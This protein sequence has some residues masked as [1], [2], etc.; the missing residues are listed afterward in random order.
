MRAMVPKHIVPIGHDAPDGARAHR[1]ER[2]RIAPAAQSARHQGG[3]TLAGFIDRF[4][5]GEGLVL[6]LDTVKRTVAVLAPRGGTRT[7]AATVLVEEMVADR[8]PVVILDPSGT[9]HGLSRATDG[10]GPG[11]PVRILGGA[12]GGLEVREHSGAM[13]AD[14]A[15]DWQQPLVVDLSSLTPRGAHRFV[16]DFA[17]QVGLRSPRI[18]H[19]VV[20][21][22]HELFAGLGGRAGPLFELLSFAGRSGAIG[23][24]L[25]SDRPSEISP[26]VLEHVD[27]LVAARTR[28]PSEH[29][30]IRSWLKPRVDEGTARR[31]LEALP[32]LE[33][34]EAWVCSPAWLR[35][36]RRVTLRH[37]ATYNGFGARLNPLRPPQSRAAAAE[38]RR[39]H[40]RLGEAREWPPPFTAFRAPT[41]PNLPYALSEGGPELDDL[42]VA[43]AADDEQVGKRRRGRPVEPLVLTTS[44]KAALKRHVASAKGNPQLALR[45]QI[46]LG[47]AEGRLN[48]DVA[49]D[50]SISIA[51]VGRWR[52]RFVQERLRGLEAPLSAVP[53]DS[54]ER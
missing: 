24:T 13:V 17:R 53:L 50:L 5:L 44:E 9:W 18:L 39:L 19:I 10:A 47:C 52:R 33:A 48:G 29:G 27:V 30:A 14:C 15:I 54:S 8:L 28:G 25:V 4:V 31:M 6:P 12:L 22:A 21:S 34:D 7:H 32:Q 51:M 37:R 2:P 49:R 23:L 46:V 3:A 42:A 1:R 36:S 35:A 38:L 11:L 20:E 41:I 43:P 26:Q 45:A 40:T 16:S